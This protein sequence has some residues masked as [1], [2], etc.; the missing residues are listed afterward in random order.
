MAAT[1]SGLRRQLREAELPDS[2]L[3]YD[4]YLRLRANGLRIYNDAM[5]SPQPEI[6]DEVDSDEEDSESDDNRSD[7]ESRDD[8]PSEPPSVGHS[9]IKRKRENDKEDVEDDIEEPGLLRPISL[10]DIPVE[11]I[12]N[13]IGYLD[14]GG[15]FNLVLASPHLF[16]AGNVNAFMLEPEGRRN[17]AD[18]NELS[19][20]EWVVLRVGREADFRTK[21]HDLIQCVV[22]AY[23]VTYPSYSLQDRSGEARV[24]E[25]MVYLRQVGVNP[26]LGPAVREGE[27]DIVQLLILLGE[28]VNQRVNNLQPLEEATVLIKIRSSLLHMNRLHVVFALLAGDADTTSTRDDYPVPT[29]PRARVLFRGVAAAAEERRLKILN[30]PGWAPTHHPTNWPVIHNPCDL[31]ARQFLG[32][33]RSPFMDRVSMALTLIA[34]RTTRYPNFEGYHPSAPNIGGAE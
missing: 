12:I 18:R 30:Y 25:I 21:H 27:A 20:L 14:A 13:I 3:K 2:S 5:A 10:A 24:E 9:G 22:D 4:L 34:A 16:L 17:A 23:L 15:V 8:V 11:L 6:S 28:D 32:D 26:V 19:L 29:P 7:E 31:T 1:T 33:E